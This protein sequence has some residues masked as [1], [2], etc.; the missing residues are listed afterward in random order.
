ME[1]FLSP[2][3]Q[4]KFSDEENEPEKSRASNYTVSTGHCCVCACVCVFVHVHVHVCVCVL[5]MVRMVFDSVN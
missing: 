3:I 4:Q 2:S 1:G 5:I